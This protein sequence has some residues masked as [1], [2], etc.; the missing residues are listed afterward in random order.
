MAN[1]KFTGNFA[2][3]ETLTGTPQD[4]TAA[5]VD[6]GQELNVEGARTVALWATLDIN[7]GADARV[8]LLAKHTEGATETEYVL[9][10]YTVAA[11]VVTV[12]PEYIEFDNDAD[13]SMLLAS[14]LD[15]VVRVV[16]WQVQAGTPGT[17]A[18]QIDDAKVSTGI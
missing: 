7:A 11:A 12:K 5:W 9:P 2:G 15:G 13:Q 17:P 3:L 8:R 4:L 18:A 10:I 1:L 16:Q 14:T 6:L